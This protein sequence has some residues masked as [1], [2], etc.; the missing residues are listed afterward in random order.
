MKTFF[1]FADCKIHLCPPEDEGLAVM[2]GESCSRGREVESQH[3]CCNIVL[4]FVNTYI[5][6]KEAVDGPFKKRL[7]FL[8]VSHDRNHSFLLFILSSLFV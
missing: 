6:G 5:D 8:N 1:T 2:E 4:M 7:S 3:I